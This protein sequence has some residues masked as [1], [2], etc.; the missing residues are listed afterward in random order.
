MPLRYLFCDALKITFLVVF[1]T[2]LKGAFETYAFKI[3]ICFCLKD[4]FFRS[5]RRMDIIFSRPI[6]DYISGYGKSY[7]LYKCNHADILPSTTSRR[8]LI[9]LKVNTSIA[10]IS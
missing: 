7:Q 4:D 3:T 9:N 2:L 8:V 6:V 5:R 1:L 10:I